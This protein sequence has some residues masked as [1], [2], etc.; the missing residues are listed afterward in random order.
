MNSIKSTK[1]MSGFLAE[2]PMLSSTKKVG[3]KPARCERVYKRIAKRDLFR[4]RR[5]S[6]MNV[7]GFTLQ[8]DPRYK[9]ER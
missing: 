7:S 3:S 5:R 1:N 9:R 2:N 8:K 4:K 6:G